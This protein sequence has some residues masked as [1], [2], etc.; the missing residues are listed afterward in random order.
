M[1]EGALLVFTRVPEPYQTK[2]RLIP[3]LGA[4]GAADFHKGLLWQTLGS[5]KA[6]NYAA[7]ELWCDGDIEH[8]FLRH[9]G[10]HYVAK[11]QLQQGVDLGERMC[12]AIEDGLA[13][14][15]FVTLIGS[16]CPT[17]SVDI[18]NQ[19]Y[20]YLCSGADAVLGPSN[21]GGYYLIGL[22]CVSPSIFAD[23]AWGGADVAQQTRENLQGLK[24]DC[25]ELG[26]LADIDTA[27]DY[28]QYQSSFL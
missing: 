4:Q 2:T 5:G 17:L 20:H 24:L 16:D 9:C 14:Y 11:M 1:A 28:W 26:M 10:E 23:V 27:D 13:E 3:A 7:L 21:D 15:D 12:F 25:I 6:S 22:R 18:L 8:P 19:S